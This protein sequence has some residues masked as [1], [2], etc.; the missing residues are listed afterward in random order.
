MLKKVHSIAF[1]ADDRTREIVH[2]I[3]VHSFESKLYRL[4]YKFAKKY[5]ENYSYLGTVRINRDPNSLDQKNCDEYED[6]IYLHLQ[7]ILFLQ[8]L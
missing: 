5:S 2:Y 7:P 6:L 1:F 4:I 3:A 8:Q